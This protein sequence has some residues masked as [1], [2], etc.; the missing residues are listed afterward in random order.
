MDEAMDKA[1]FLGGDAKRMAVMV[2][3]RW[4][5]HAGTGLRR[6]KQIGKVQFTDRAALCVGNPQTVAACL[7]EG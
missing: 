1:I 5:G 7:H 2:S 4:H 6:A 3:S